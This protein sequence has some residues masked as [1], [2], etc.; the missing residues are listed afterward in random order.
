MS[1]LYVYTMTSQH[2]MCENLKILVLSTLNHRRDKK[3]LF[4]SFLNQKQ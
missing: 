4:I 3:S 1:I 2:R